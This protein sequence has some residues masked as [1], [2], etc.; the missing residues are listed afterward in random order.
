MNA[1]EKAKMT[2]DAITLALLGCPEFRRKAGLPPRDG[3][4]SSLDEMAAILGVT[5]SRVCQVY[6]TAISK[7]RN[8]MRAHINH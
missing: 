5:K 6:T 2:E 8:A 1:K 7:L 4:G 3:G